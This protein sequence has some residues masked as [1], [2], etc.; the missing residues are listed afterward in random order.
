AARKWRIKSTEEASRQ[1]ITFYTRHGDVFAVTAVAASVLILGLG[2][3]PRKEEDGTKRISKNMID[4]LRTKYEGLA[5]QAD[6]LRR[7][8]G[9]G[10]KARRAQPSGGAGKPA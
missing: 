4:E 8:V 9:R 2:F 5:D 10:C 6:Q 1:S 7:Y 3:Y